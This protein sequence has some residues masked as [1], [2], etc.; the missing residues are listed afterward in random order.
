MD[1]KQTTSIK[2][3]RNSRP[4]YSQGGYSSGGALTLMSILKN[5]LLAEEAGSNQRADAGQKGHPFDM[6]ACLELKEM[7][8]HHSTCID[9]KISSTVGVGHERDETHELL[10]ELCE[11]SWQAV[12]NDAAEDYWGCGQ[13]RIEVVRDGDEIVGLHHLPAPSTFIFQEEESHLWHY[14]VSP[15]GFML[16]SRKFSR[17]GD[18]ERVAEKY[19]QDVTEVSEVISFKRPSA[20]NRWYSSPDWLAAVPSI[21]L[22]HC[23][24]QHTF[25]FFLNRGVPEF[26]MFVTGHGLREEDWKE[27]EEIFQAQIGLGNSHKSAAFNWPSPEIKVQ[28]EKLA[29]EG[30]TDGQYNDIAEALAMSIVSAHKVPPLLAGIA[31]PGKLGAA[32]ELPNALMAFQVLLIEQAQRMWSN[33]MDCTLGKKVL[34]GG[35]ALKRGDF[36]F[37]KITDLIDLGQMDTVSRMKEPVASAQASG[38]KVEDGLKS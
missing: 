9:T 7:Q 4:L 34:N 11:D 30:K 20:Q 14:D 27:V 21:E 25:D 31:L 6:Q 28:I 19:E 24:R 29:L 10:D 12:L 17:F 3:P 35:L 37:K 8:E 13:G 5:V 16:P 2:V 15:G 1:K 32:N 26:M 18:R 22:M 38:R 23:L 36:V 33:T